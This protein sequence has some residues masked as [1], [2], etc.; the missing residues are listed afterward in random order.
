MFSESINSNYRYRIV[1]PEELISLQRQIHGNVSR[2]SFVTDTDS[3]IAQP[4]VR[5]P[6]FFINCRPDPPPKPPI[7]PP[8]LAGLSVV[9]C[10]PIRSHTRRGGSLEILK[11]GGREAGVAIYENLGFPVSKPG[12]SQSQGILP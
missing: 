11:G 9:L 7:P 2:N 4:R 5:K 12:V 3:E 1:P 10:T 6:W 8:K